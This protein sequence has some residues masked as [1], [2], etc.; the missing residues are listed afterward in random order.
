MAD[1][2]RVTQSD[3]RRIRGLVVLAVFA[4]ILHILRRPL[5]CAYL[6]ASVLF[7][8]FVTMGATR[9]FFE[10][11]APEQFNGFDWKLPL[12]LF[13]IL[14]AVGQD[15]NIYLATRVFEEQKRRG[16][17]PGLRRAIVKTGA[18]ITSCGLIMAGTFSSMATGSLRGLIEMG[19]ALALGVLFDTFIV[20]PILVPAFLALL[21]RA[22]PNGGATEER[23]TTGAYETPRSSPQPPKII[24]TS[25]LQTGQVAQNSSGK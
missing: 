12:F 6:I 19:F 7:S 14:V 21:C 15:Y 20:R 3:Q 13:V 9:W 25:D 24:T 11:F 23:A 17:L 2:E 4:V 8:Y 1:L 18:A 16:L 22:A 10:T 5:V